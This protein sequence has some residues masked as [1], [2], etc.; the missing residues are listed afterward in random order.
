MINV[1]LN[2]TG[3][4]KELDDKK[5]AITNALLDAG[6]KRNEIE[7]YTDINL[8]DLRAHLDVEVEVR[9]RMEAYIAK[10]PKKRTT[11]SKA[12]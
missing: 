12:A 4:T 3:I 1:L 5:I 10:Q 2:A 7:D 9:G 8:D 11:Q 6:F